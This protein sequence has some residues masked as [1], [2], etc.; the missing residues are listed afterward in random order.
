MMTSPIEN[1]SP[2]WVEL[3]ERSKAVR[4]LNFRCVPGRQFI[5]ALLIGL[6]APGFALGQA[7]T[8]P[9]NPRDYQRMME[10]G[11]ES[12]DPS[13]E[14]DYGYEEEMGYGED[15]GEGYGGSGAR[16]G[17]RPGNPQEGLAQQFRNVMMSVFSRRTWLRSPIPRRHRPSIQDPCCLTK[18]HWLMQMAI[19]RS[20]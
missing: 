13:M 19:Y 6:I 12:D 8:G 7:T 3:L 16:P 9:T 17:G 18:P 4:G 5:A 10:E 15:Y 11:M 20:D 1:A 2:R 14:D